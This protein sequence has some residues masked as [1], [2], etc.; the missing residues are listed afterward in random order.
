MALFDYENLAV[1][2]GTFFF[3]FHICDGNRLREAKMLS[4]G[5]GTPHSSWPS[6]AR[7]VSLGHSVPHSTNKPWAVSPAPAQGKQGN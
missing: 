4:R 1:L 2:N 7:L 3:F 5:H 6:T